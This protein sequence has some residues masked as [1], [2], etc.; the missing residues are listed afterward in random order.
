MSL[1]SEK[2]EW[3]YP[4]T[5]YD[6]DER[7]QRMQV[8][9]LVREFEL[10]RLKDS[11]T[12]KQYSDCLLNIDNHIRLLGSTFK[13]SRNVKKILVIGPE[14]F[15]ASIKTIENTKDLSNI[16]VTTLLSAF[17]VQEQECVIKQ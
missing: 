14:W 7:I 4:T 17:Q 5:E 13:D 15:E 6:G 3:D 9:N 12:I 1:K 8:L 11:E 2:E 10:L 16:T